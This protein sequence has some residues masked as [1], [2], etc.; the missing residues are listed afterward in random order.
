MRLYRR[1]YPLIRWLV[2]PSD[3]WTTDPLVNNYDEKKIR[4]DVCE[5]IA[6]KRIKLES[7][8]CSDLQFFKFASKPEQLGLSNLICL[9]AVMK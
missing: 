4:S 9:E 6:S 3:G 8:G 2:R 5:H 7:P 1:V